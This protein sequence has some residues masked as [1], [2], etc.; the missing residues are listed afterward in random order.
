MRSV[1]FYRFDLLQ[2][3]GRL[4]MF[5][6][7]GFSIGVRQSISFFQQPSMLSLQFVFFIAE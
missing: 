6:V 4:G 3:L 1:T 5:L 7:A 2:H